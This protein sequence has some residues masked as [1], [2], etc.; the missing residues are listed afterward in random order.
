MIIVRCYKY[1]KVVLKVV[2]FVM[3]R[4]LDDGNEGIYVMFNGGVRD[5]IRNEGFVLK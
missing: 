5:I 1:D 3:C 2:Y 4:G